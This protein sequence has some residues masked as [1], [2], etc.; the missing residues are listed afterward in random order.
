MLLP[1]F[2]VISLAFW[3]LIPGKS[4]PFIISDQK[5][6]TDTSGLFGL[7][8]KV[9]LLEEKVDSLESS[10]SAL[11]SK[12]SKLESGKTAIQVQTVTVAK[13]RK[14]PVLIPINPGGDINTT[15]WSNLTSGSITIDTA[16]YPGYKNAYLIINLSVNVGQGKASARL[17][18]PANS[19]A[20]LGSE[21]S[22]A[23]YTPVSLTSGSFNFPSG[24]NTYTIQLK[25]LVKGY[26]AQAADSFLQI[27]Y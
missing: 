18:N 6:V 24:I 16:D 14:S 5:Q 11:L 26:P 8:N 17:V 13:P 19:L 3:F 7:S 9:N 23:S 10:N 4:S 25:T 2:A 21:V 22:T 20:I 15:D 12:I 1:V 27:T